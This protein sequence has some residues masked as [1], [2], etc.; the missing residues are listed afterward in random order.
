M[1][2]CL[3]FQDCLCI[4][5]AHIW[6]TVD[7]SEIQW[8]PV[9]VATIPL[10]IIDPVRPT[11]PSL[12]VSWPHLSLEQVLQNGPKV[13]PI[14]QK[15]KTRLKEKGLTY[16]RSWTKGG[17]VSQCYSNTPLPSWKVHQTSP[18][19]FVLSHFRGKKLLGLPH[20]I[21][22][23]FFT[24]PFFKMGVKIPKICGLPPPSNSCQHVSRVSKL[25]GSKMVD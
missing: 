22:W 21:I 12:D 18:K 6:N 10:V 19:Q 4:S 15:N 11:K 9:D 5:N 14:P 1:T 7:V 13:V 3:S 20:H 25:M 16:K 8:K 24:N 17:I 23:W 2:I